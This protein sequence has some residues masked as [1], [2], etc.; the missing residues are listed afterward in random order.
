MIY[1]FP[2]VWMVGLFFAVDKMTIGFQG[3]HKDKIHITYKNEGD[4]FQ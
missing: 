1:I 3:M 4:V 2:L